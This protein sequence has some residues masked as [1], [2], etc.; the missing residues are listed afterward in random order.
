MRGKSFFSRLFGGGAEAQTRKAPVQ[1]K[2][3]NPDDAK[4]NADFWNMVHVNSAHAFLSYGDAYMRSC[5]EFEAIDRDEFGNALAFLKLVIGTNGEMEKA[6]EKYHTDNMF[7]IFR[8]IRQKG[9]A[10]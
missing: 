8:T 3:T 10:K 1:S 7:Q 6:K 2:K 5:T 4:R 9:G